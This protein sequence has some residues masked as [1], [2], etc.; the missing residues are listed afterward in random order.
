VTVDPGMQS[1]APSKLA[2]LFAE[3]EQYDKMTR[4][5]LAVGLS[6]VVCCC[7]QTTHIC[8]ILV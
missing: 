8:Y 7:T 6:L 2:A 5:Y 3:M 4:D 1:D